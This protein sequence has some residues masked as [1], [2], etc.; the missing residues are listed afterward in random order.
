[1]GTTGNTPAATRPT[2]QVKDMTVEELRCE[3]YRLRHKITEVQNSL[4]GKQ[5]IIE[6]LQA[7]Q[8]QKMIGALQDA[9]KVAIWTSKPH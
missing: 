3:V 4:K 6:H 7:S 9:V 2:K 5:A 8:Q 1:M